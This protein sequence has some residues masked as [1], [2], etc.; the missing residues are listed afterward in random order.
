LFLSFGRNFDEVTSCPKDKKINADGIRLI[1]KLKKAKSLIVKY[2]A[3]RLLIRTKEIIPINR[4]TKDQDI[5]F[6]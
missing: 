4:P 2:L 3:A 1:I 5:F 6:I